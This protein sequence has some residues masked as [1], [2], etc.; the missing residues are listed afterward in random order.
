MEALLLLKVIP[1]TMDDR[2][3]IRTAS[4][5]GQRSE[6]YLVPYCLGK[7]GSRDRFKHKSARQAKLDNG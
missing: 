5:F 6:N 2:V 4:T 7:L 1:H 3:M